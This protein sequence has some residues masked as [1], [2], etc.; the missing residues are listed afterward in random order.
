MDTEFIYK[1]FKYESEY[2][3]DNLKDRVKYWHN[4]FAFEMVRQNSVPDTCYW[5]V[6]DELF[7]DC[8]VTDSN[9]PNCPKCEPQDFLKYFQL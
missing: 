3:E 2:E 1:R 8:I 7:K 4:K 9:R 5:C 6:F